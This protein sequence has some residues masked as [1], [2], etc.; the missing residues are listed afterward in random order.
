MSFSSDVKEEL[1]TFWEKPCEESLRRGRT[2]TESGGRND[3]IR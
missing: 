2:R 3:Q 1:K